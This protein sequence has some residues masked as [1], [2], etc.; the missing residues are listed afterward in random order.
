MTLPK[1]TPPALGLGG[2]ASGLVFVSLTILLGVLL[3]YFVETKLTIGVRNF[4]DQRFTK[5]S[6]QKAAIQASR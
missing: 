6:K 1:K 2:P 4:L 3:H 5:V